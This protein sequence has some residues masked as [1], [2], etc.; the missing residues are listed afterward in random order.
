MAELVPLGARF[1]RSHRSEYLW[2]AVQQQMAWFHSLQVHRESFLAVANSQ[3]ESSQYSHLLQRLELPA[4]LDL[5]L[6]QLGKIGDPNQVW[7]VSQAELNY[8]SKVL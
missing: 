8:R 1:P 6:L 4:P 5:K 7:V 3:Q 2:A